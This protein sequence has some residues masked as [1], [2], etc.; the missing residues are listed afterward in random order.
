MIFY[1]KTNLRIFFDMIKIF[2][3]KFR[4]GGRH[5]DKNIQLD[6][7][8]EYF[9]DSLPSYTP[10]AYLTSIFVQNEYIRIHDQNVYVVL[11]HS[12]SDICQIRGITPLNAFGYKNPKLNKKRDE[13]FIK[14]KQILV[15]RFRQR[16]LEDPE[17]LPRNLYPVNAWKYVYLYYLSDSRVPCFTVYDN[18]EWEID[19][20]IQISDMI[21]V[22]GTVNI[23]QSSEI[24]EVVN[25]ISTPI[26]MT[27]SGIN[28]GNSQGGEIM[29]E[30]HEESYYTSRL[31]EIGCDVIHVEQI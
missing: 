12:K 19:S 25:N 3:V 5:F 14:I 26:T 16:K 17:F 22:F 10:R 31:H 8:N 21:N 11:D 4:A 1:N 23:Y 20:L 9:L 13:N 6:D 30:S 18:F 15:Q 29:C 24:I 27:F 28:R 2:K 7:V